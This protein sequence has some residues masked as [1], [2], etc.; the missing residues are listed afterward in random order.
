MFLNSESYHKKR[1]CKYRLR[2]LQ[3]LFYPTVLFALVCF[4]WKWYNNHDDFRYA[5]E[6][7]LQA[8]YD[9]YVKYWST[10]KNQTETERILIHHLGISASFFNSK[11]KMLDIGTGDGR[12]ALGFAKGYG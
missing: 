9:K 11:T 6:Q 3:L 10:V 7:K 4:W 8:H 2:R 5:K 12:L 1:L